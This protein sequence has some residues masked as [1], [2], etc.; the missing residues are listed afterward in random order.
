MLAFL[1]DPPDSE[2]ICYDIGSSTIS[3]C[4]N[5]TSITP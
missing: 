5:V 3:D 2:H 4:S 1:P